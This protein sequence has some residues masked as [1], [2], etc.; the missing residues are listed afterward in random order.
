MDG[1][2]S[3]PRKTRLYGG[4]TVMIVVITALLI[5]ITRRPD[6]WSTPQLWSEDGT[7]FFFDAATKGWASWPTPYAGY[8]HLVPRT[9]ACLTIGLSWEYIP[10]VYVWIAAL[11]A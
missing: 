4:A 6:L 7:T 8:L 5:Y 10:T 3:L 1:E 2:P 11:V 9:I